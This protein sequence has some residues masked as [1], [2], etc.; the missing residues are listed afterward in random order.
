MGDN[1]Q[2]DCCRTTARSEK[3]KRDLI[4]RLSRIEGQ[5]RGIRGMLENDLY[6]VDILNQAAAAGSALDSFSRALLE[7]HIRT[8]VA[9]DLREGNQEKLDE[10][11]LILKKLT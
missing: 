10:L 8:C 4:N 11:M 1:E 2:R 6:C 3:E 5:I 7:E 9:Q